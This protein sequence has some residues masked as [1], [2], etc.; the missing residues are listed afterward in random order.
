[1][2]R[3]GGHRQFL[4]MRLLRRRLPPAGTP[5]GLVDVLV[6]CAGLFDPETRRTS[7]RAWVKRE[8]RARHCFLTSS[9]RTA[10]WLLLEAMKRLVAEPPQRVLVPA[11]TCASLPSAILR[12]GL[13]PV[14]VRLDEATLDYH[15]AT[16]AAAI[17]RHRPLALLA[18]NLFGMPGNSPRWAAMAKGAGAFF[19]DDAAQ[20]LGS[21]SNGRPCGRWGDAGFY[22]LARGKNI[23]A[24]GG[25]ILVTDRDDLA[26]ILQREAERLGAVSHR[27][28]IRTVAEAVVFWSLLRP[29]FFWLARHIPG[30]R[31]QVFEI[32]SAFGARGMG[33]AQ[34]I[35]ARRSWRRL[36]EAN[37]TRRINGQR[38]RAGLAGASGVRIPTPSGGFASWLRLPVLFDDPSARD[39]AAATLSQAGLGASVIYPTAWSRLDGCPVSDDSGADAAGDLP[40]RLLALATHRLVQPTDIAA[41]AQIVAEAAGGGCRP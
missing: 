26:E 34:A 22:S 4:L 36:A 15:E 27:R 30:V 12:A 5:I 3:V 25:G 21:W 33:G 23:T 16:L 20:T 37:A 19:I 38:L 13:T 7:L 24:M 14:P 10:L 41:A 8:T 29:H 28:E 17:E 9:G 40:A 6:A 35:L 39:R 18:V 11:Y 31:L 32:D 2:P 1:M